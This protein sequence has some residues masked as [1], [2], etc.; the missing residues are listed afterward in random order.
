MQ[1]IAS[2]VGMIGVNKRISKVER[3]D[4]ET[5]ENHLCILRAVRIRRGHRV[6]TAPMAMSMARN[7]PIRMMASE[8]I[9]TPVRIGYG[10][11][12]LADSLAPSAIGRGRAI[13]PLVGVQGLP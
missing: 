8:V 13:A 12:S 10:S 4:T 3:T 7:E 5:L 11:I 1:Y 9:E 6:S 2:A